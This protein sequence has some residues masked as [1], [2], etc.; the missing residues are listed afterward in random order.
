MR[1]LAGLAQRRFKEAAPGGRCTWRPRWPMNSPKAVSQ[2]LE[3]S[4]V[5]KRG[6]CTLVTFSWLVAVLRTA[7]VSPGRAQPRSDSSSGLRARGR[8]PMAAYTEARVL[9]RTSSTSTILPIC[10][11][12]D[13]KTFLE[14][15]AR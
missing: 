5:N 2:G 10:S 4:V 3:G 12:E 13:S 6:I 9:I 7:S 1:A 14:K 15:H 8:P 11:K